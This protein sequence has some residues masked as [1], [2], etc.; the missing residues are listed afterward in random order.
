MSHKACRTHTRFENNRCFLPAFW[1]ARRQ[2]G[3]G[4]EG[5]T[6]R[7]QMTL[8]IMAVEMNEIK[9]THT[10]AH[11]CCTN[12]P[13]KGRNGVRVHSVDQQTRANKGKQIK[14]RKQEELHAMHRCVSDVKVSCSW[15]NSYRHQQTKRTRQAA[16]V[17]LVA[18]KK[19]VPLCSAHNHPP[20]HVDCKPACTQRTTKR[21]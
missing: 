3:G 11:T 19:N 20:T 15:H 8:V 12:M 6:R 17:R 10:Y 4:R 16:G 7:C 14:G 18:I 1:S 2:E 21:P 9:P 13:I 5:C